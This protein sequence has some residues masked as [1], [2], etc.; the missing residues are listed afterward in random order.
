MRQ[1]YRD[2]CVWSSYI[3]RS[4]WLCMRE[5]HINMEYGIG[6]QSYILKQYQEP[7]LTTVY[8]I[9][10][11]FNA[12]TDMRSFRFKSRQTY[13]TTTSYS[14]LSSISV[15]IWSL[16]VEHGVATEHPLSPSQERSRKRSAISKLSCLYCQMPST[17]RKPRS[18][19]VDLNRISLLPSN[20]SL[21]PY[22]SLPR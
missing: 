4:R 20:V 12:L 17:R 8:S 7:H 3:I 9:A 6:A 22:V 10:C 19:P 14:D 2:W 11:K 1:Q 18:M 16:H 13:R 5:L 21:P 15:I